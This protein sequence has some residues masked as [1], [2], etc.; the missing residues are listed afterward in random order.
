MWP[1]KVEENNTVL[2]ALS[3]FSEVQEKVESL[4]NEQALTPHY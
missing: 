4:L 2:R 1:G 3:R